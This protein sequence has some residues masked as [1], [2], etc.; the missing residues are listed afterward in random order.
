MK[1][2]S[3][4]PGNCPHNVSKDA[5]YSIRGTDGRVGLTYRAADDERW[6]MTTKDHPLLAEMV[7][8]VKRTHG[9]AP[10]GPFYI[11]EY[12]Q[13]IVPVGDEAQY[14]FAGTYEEP[15]HFE[16]EGKTIS[17]EPHDLD[18][19][20]F[21]P[22]DTWTGPHA[23]IPY[24]LT[25]SGNDVYYRTFPRPDVEKRVKLS[26]HQG[27]GAAE[28]I[29]RL[30]SAFKGSGGGRFYVN[31]FCSVFSR[32]NGTDGWQYIYIGQIDLNAWFPDPLASVAVA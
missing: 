32:I 4:F 22:G 30:L 13:V 15:L 24:V 16:F 18:G 1:I 21:R 6:H 10:N 27:R 20:P 2:F 17:G 14:Y 5:K 19:K 29:A 25:A 12:R 9:T 26:A 8:D 3:V 7:N 23:G 11:N 31:E 28:Q